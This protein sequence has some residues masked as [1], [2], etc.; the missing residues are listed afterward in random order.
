MLDKIGTAQMTEEIE[1]RV[2]K[3]VKANSE[4]LMEATGI[5][6]MESEENVKRYISEIVAELNTAKLD[7]ARHVKDPND[8]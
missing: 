5:E 3:V 7:G 6:A 2:I 8:L 1:K 4:K